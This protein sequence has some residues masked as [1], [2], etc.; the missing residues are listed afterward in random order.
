MA[1]F[2]QRSL[3]VQDHPL[4]SQDFELLE[5]KCDE[6]IPTM[7]G[8]HTLIGGWVMTQWKSKAPGCQPIG[9]TFKIDIFKIQIW[10]LCTRWIYEKNSG[11]ECHLFSIHQTPCQDYP[12][13]DWAMKSTRSRTYLYFP[14]SLSML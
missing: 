11:E 5:K 13:C 8:K 2:T 7:L 6:F 3:R 1:W 10:L 9:L 4:I 12:V 14:E